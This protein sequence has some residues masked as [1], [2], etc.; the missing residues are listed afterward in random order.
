MVE[1]LR[2]TTR[3]EREVPTNPK[4]SWPNRREGTAHFG[5]RMKPAAGRAQ[6]DHLAATHFANCDA[7]LS[8]A[9]CE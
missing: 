2:F 8:F 5:G 9:E 7:E 3:A 1:Q 6:S 4:I